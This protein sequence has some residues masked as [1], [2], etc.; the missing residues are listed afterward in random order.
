MN[1]TLLVYILVIIGKF[2]K[3]SYT[4]HCVYK[5]SWFI[6]LCG[7]A[8]GAALIRKFILIYVWKKSQDP[9]FVQAKI[10]FWWLIFVFSIELAV[11]I[12]GNCIFFD[13]EMK[14]CKNKGNLALWDCC[15]VVLIY[16]YFFMLF[17]LLSG[18]F[19]C[20]VF[21][22]YRSWSTHDD[23]LPSETQKDLL[24]TLNEIPILGNADQ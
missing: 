14:T 7:Y 5:L 15:L 2:W 24:M 3:R 19:Y 20:M 10:D 18:C 23:E 11:Y 21:V 6:I 8:Q 9:G 16:G 1:V 13:P 4:E 22:L 17:L 12:W